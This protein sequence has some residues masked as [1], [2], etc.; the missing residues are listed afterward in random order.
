MTRMNLQQL[1]YIHEVAKRGLN[2]SEAAAAL[3]TSQPGVSKQIRLLE[4][5]LGITVFVRRGK[6]IT[7]ITEPGQQVLAIVD[8]LLRDLTNLKQVGKEY[9]REVT[10]RLTIA[11]THTQARY[12]LP[13]VIQDFVQRYPAVTLALRQGNPTQ[14]CEYVLTGEADIAVATEAIEH[15]DELVMLPCYQW[16]RCVIAPPGHPILAAAPLTLE[17]IAKYPIVTYDFAFA[18]RGQINKAFAAR[19]LVPNV[20]LT[21]IDADIIKTY[22]ALG[23]GVGVVAAMAF[24]PQRDTQLRAADASHLFEWA[25]TRIGLRK[26]SYL[27]GYVYGFIEL[28]APQLS[29]KVVDGALAG[30]GSDPGL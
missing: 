2:I 10:G 7:G 14:V 28:F 26:G 23:L 20:V 18:G 5:E 25:T 11:T 4:D 21:A 22:V 29:R 8:R 12:K 24:D 3:F 15:Y 17:E 6:R 30:G 16:N 13:S 9:A 27:R 19:G 1:R